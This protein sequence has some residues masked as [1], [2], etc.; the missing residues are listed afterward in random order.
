[1]DDLHSGRLKESAGLEQTEE[2][3]E[4]LRPERMASSVPGMDGEELLEVFG[5]FVHD[6]TRQLKAQCR[7]RAGL[8]VSYDNLFGYAVAGLLEAKQ[9]FDPDAGSAF[10]TFAY[11]RIRGAIL[12]GI[13]RE[14]WGPRSKRKLRSWRAVD[15]QT[16]ARQK[17][18]SDSPMASSLAGSL[19]SIKETVFDAYAVQF[20]Y[21]EHL[22]T[23]FAHEE[24]PEEGAEQTQLQKTIDDA[25]ADLPD[26]QRE[27]IIRYHVKD[28]TMREIA[29]SFGVSKSWVSRLNAQ[30][31]TTLR[32]VLQEEGEWL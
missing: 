32:M 29:Q 25:L 1:M 3:G 4:Q 17:I 7:E 14:G 8:D 22:E 10:T 6:I 11:Y 18:T 28:E 20:L 23:R 31:M 26:R 24:T 12:D 2:T 9:S 13:Q 30:A 19:A 15:E 21:D 16:H 5:D 27:V